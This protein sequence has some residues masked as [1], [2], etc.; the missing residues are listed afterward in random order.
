VLDLKTQCGKRKAK[1]NFTVSDKT[2][3]ETEEKATL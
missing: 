3:N 1:K 2:P